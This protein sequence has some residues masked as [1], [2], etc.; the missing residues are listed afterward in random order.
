MSLI[1]ER[2]EHIYD[3]TKVAL[4]PGRYAFDTSSHRVV[5]DTAQRTA[6]VDGGIISLFPGHEEA[7]PRT[8][9]A[10]VLYSEGKAHKI[11]LI[12][13]GASHSIIL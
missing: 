10:E 13:L 11:T 3:P 9:N 6:L 2:K 8:I 5:V 1:K 12:I 4:S 7:I